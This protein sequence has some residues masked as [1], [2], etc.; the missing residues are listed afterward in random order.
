MT[1]LTLDLGT[2]T[3]K[4]ALWSG[5]DLLDL[6]RAPL[7]TRHPRPGW[8]EQDPED[9]WS[10]VDRATASLREARPDAYA[11]VSMIGCS[12]ARETF[13]PFDR[14]LRPLG[15]GILW[16]D[17]RATDE[18]EA[19]GDP[20]AFRAATGVILGPGC[21]AA[22]VAWLRRHEPTTFDHAVWL[23]APRDLVLARLT[24]RARTDPTLASRTGLYDLGGAFL[25]DD[26]LAERL[27][28]V[29][30]SL[31]PAPVSG[32]VF[33]LPGGVSAI[34][35]AGD[36][37]CEATGVGATND[38]PVVSWGTTLNVSAPHPGPASALPTHAQVSRAVRTPFLI[39]AG[40]AAAGAAV[41][42]LARLTGRTSGELLELAR[43]APPGARG[44][45]ALPWLH[46]ARAP[47]WRPDVEAVLCGLTSAHGPAELARALIEGVAFDTAR[48]V[49]LVAPDASI[50]EV[51]GGGGPDSL[52]RSILAAATR[53][54]LRLRRHAEAASVGA[55]ILVADADDTAL[56][57]DA[58]NP[59]TTIEAPSEA[60]SDDYVELRAR[61]D[62]VALAML[63]LPP[64]AQ[65]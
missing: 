57:L 36:R 38:A 60:L 55:R 39:E 56:A 19:L 33:D 41:E 26:A 5:P 28:E 23:L 63:D 6:A 7:A 12:G 58:V 62:R 1:V 53:R 40:L 22:K 42:W 9:W 47:W 43:G 24:G 17:A 35:G 16:S 18:V 25:G 48:S 31:E 29:V 52:W 3:T 49:E 65:R 11:A 64:A 4:A 15:A 37:C 45:V 13:A 59:V 54:E 2:S 30:P 8:A 27:P 61:S 32:A 21:C 44:A 14:Q 50:L 34:L 51:A 46:G 20:A 10:S